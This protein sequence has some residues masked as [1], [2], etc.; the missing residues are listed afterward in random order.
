MTD[1]DETILHTLKVLLTLSS[2]RV[3]GH[4]RMVFERECAIKLTMAGT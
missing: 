1:V 3:N 4:K 2:K